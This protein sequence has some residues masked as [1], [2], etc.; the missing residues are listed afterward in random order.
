MTRCWLKC[1]HCG[2]QE[3]VLSTTEFG[4]CPNCGGGPR[5]AQGDN[6]D[7]MIVW[8]TAQDPT[9]WES[10]DTGSFD[11]APTDPSHGGK[12]WNE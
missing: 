12:V 2:T 9:S 1:P 10:G 5:F 8:S 4:P 11:L 7:P 6:G 3:L